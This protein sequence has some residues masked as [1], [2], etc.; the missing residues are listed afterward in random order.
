M[1]SVCN[2]KCLV[3]VFLSHDYLDVMVTFIM[4]FK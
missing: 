3:V 1:T 4:V 2:S